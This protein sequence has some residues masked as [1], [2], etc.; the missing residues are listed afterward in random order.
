MKA[1][2]KAEQRP[3]LCP[4]SSISSK[5]KHNNRFTD[6]RDS[7]LS[8]DQV[9]YASL[10]P[11]IDKISLRSDQ[12]QESE[13]KRSKRDSLGHNFSHFSIYDPHLHAGTNQLVSHSYPFST[14]NSIVPCREKS[15]RIA[16]ILSPRELSQ[17]I[18]EDQTPVITKGPI[19][20]LQIVPGSSVKSTQ[21]GA[22]VYRDWQGLTE[23]DFNN[24][25]SWFPIWQVFSPDQENWGIDIYDLVL[26]GKITIR[27]W[28][29]TPDQ[30]I[31]PNTPN[32]VDG[33]NIND[34]PDSPCY[35]KT[36]IDL[37]GMYNSPPSAKKKSDWYATDAIIAHEWAHW[38]IDFI[39]DAVI[40]NKGGDW[41]KLN[42]KIEAQREPKSSSPSAED[43]RAPLQLKLEKYINNFRQ[44][45]EKRWNAIPDR[46][47]D[48]GS[49]GFIAGQ[50]VLDSYI[51]RIFS[52]AASKGWK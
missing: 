50:K 26:T 34:E 19:K 47:G 28:P 39:E 9:R 12:T 4:K 3:S 42:S 40:S 22:G 13:M 51:E 41:P 37:L 2:V 10:D 31:V 30:M 43:A 32:P 36:V 11:G 48:P 29:S 33:G 52:Y 45:A 7:Y 5:C 8:F 14:S 44:D 20:Y 49:T 38:N 25:V 18:A 17:N 35:W 1:Q 23:P 46:P 21:S 6:E 27:P 24:Y 15:F 16:T